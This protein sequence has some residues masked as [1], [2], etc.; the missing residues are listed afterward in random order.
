MRS[1]SI[2]SI[3]A[4]VGLA[5]V[6]LIPRLILA[7]Q[8]DVVTDEVVYL[9]AGKVY[10]PLLTHLNIG[11]SQWLLNKE[12]PPLAK[13]FMGFCIELNR[14]LGNH[15][16]EL[17][18]GRLPSIVM[19]TILVL[20]IYW[21]GRAPFGRKV[22]LI[23]AFALALSPWLCYFSAL[24]YL[25]MTMTA[26]VTLAYLV[27]WHALRRPWLFVV[28]ALFVGLGVD[29]KYPAALVIPAIV[30]FTAYYYFL[31][32][33]TMPVE[34]RSALPWGWWG[35]AVVVA[36]LAFFVADPAIWPSPVSRLLSS[37]RFEETHSSN[38][39]LTFLAG[40]VLT[41][42]PKW[43]IVYMIFT[44]MSAFLT[45]P[46]A[47]FV[48]FAVVML[49]RYHLRK[50]KFDHMQAASYAYLV[51]WLVCILVAFSFL[52]IAVGSHYY[53]PLAPSVALAGVAGLALILQFVADL[54][55]KKAQHLEHDDA[56]TVDAASGVTARATTLKFAPYVVIP[57]VLLALLAIGPHLLGVSTVY[58]AEGYT[59]EFFNN[60][61]NTRLQV[62]YPGYRDALQWLVSARH[63][64]A[65]VGLIATKGTLDGYSPTTNWFTYNKDLIGRFQLSEVLPTASNYQG[66]DYLV[67][68]KHLVQR[69]YP[70]PPHAH[71]IHVVSGGNTIYCYIL[72]IGT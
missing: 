28:M 15:I 61:E 5:I 59:T 8:L 64:N 9:F 70:L 41:H 39:H 11:S 40:Q 4:L 49:V 66:Y 33:P 35:A 58:A 55:W 2:L 50:A 25:D 34:Q 30:L 67:W 13:F 53:L 10:M 43:T 26:F 17:L 16:S 60:N 54:V 38:G 3:L 22:A 63:T 24:A 71:I 21:L 31:L 37:F 46:A 7:L 19:G 44:K 36:P 56:D 27:L 72:V 47:F 62:A 48:I 6:A 42:V 32:R 23:A 45:I 68:P 20:A 14:V 65:K 52:N 29:S 57:T 12:H 51:I 69:G 1:H 18:A